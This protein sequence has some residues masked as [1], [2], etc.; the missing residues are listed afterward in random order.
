MNIIDIKMRG[1]AMK[2]NVCSD[3]LC[4]FHLKHSSKEIRVLIFS[5]TFIRN[6]LQNKCVFWFS[7]QHLSETFLKRNVCFDFLYN[8]YLKHSSKQMCVLIFSTTLIWNIPQMKCVFS[9]SL[10]PLS[11]TFLKT[12]VCFDFLYYFYLK[13][14]SNQM[15]VLIFSTFIWNIPQNKCV[16]WF[17]LQLWSETFLKWNVCF[18]FLYYLYLKHSS[19]QCVF[20]FSLLLLSETFLKRNVCF[21]FLYYFDL[22][23]SSNEMCVF[24]F[25][26]TFIWN[27][28]QNKCVFWFSLLLLSETFL[29]T[30]VCFDFL[31]NFYL[32]HS[33]KKM[34]VLIVSTTFVWNIPQNKCVFWFSLQHLSETFLNMKRNKREIITNLHISVFMRSGRNSCQILMKLEFSRQIFEK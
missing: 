2:T 11:E 10:L 32:K 8:I 1:T 22:K 28:P 23:H 27:I 31:Y 12:N 16:F 20:W 24:I 21:D 7:L 30:N 13:H 15:C 3:F 19:K 29:K 5:T 4:N 33:S 34:C 9:F 26:T 14:S 17:S 6:I 25:S 18:H